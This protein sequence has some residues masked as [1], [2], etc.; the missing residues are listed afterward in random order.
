MLTNINLVRQRRAI[1]N[2]RKAE[3]KLARGSLVRYKALLTIHHAKYLDQRLWNKK[4]HLTEYRPNLYQR[5]F[6]PGKCESATIQRYF[7]KLTWS[8]YAWCR[9][10]KWTELRTDPAGS[11]PHRGFPGFDS[12]PYSCTTHQTPF[13]D[14]Q[15]MQ[16]SVPPM[17]LISNIIYCSE[18]LLSQD[19]IHE[20]R[21]NDKYWHAKLMY[22]RKK[23]NG[24]CTSEYKE[25]KVERVNSA[26]G[27]QCTF[28][29]LGSGTK[30]T[31]RE[32]NQFWESYSKKKL[33]I[34]K[35]YQVVRSV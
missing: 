29:E 2:G 11:A 30:L 12:T 19:H 14:H 25:R 21:G 17:L 9:S 35:K 6:D 7:F 23:K 34:P 18:I 33:S 13:A 15:S 32:F 26:I 4:M 22:R 8:S 16:Y 31:K 10:R 24:K 3:G 27:N 28:S 5:P 1:R 20:C